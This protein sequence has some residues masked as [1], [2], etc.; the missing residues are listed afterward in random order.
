MADCKADQVGQI[1]PARRTDAAAGSGGRRGIALETDCRFRKTAELRCEHLFSSSTPLAPPNMAGIQRAAQSWRPTSC[2]AS[3]AA[4]APCNWATARARLM[5]TTGEPVTPTA[6]HKGRRPLPSWGDPFGAD[7][8]APT[9]LRLRADNGQ[10]RPER[11]RAEA[12]PRLHQSFRL[13]T[14]PDPARQAER[15]RRRHCAA[16]HGGLRRAA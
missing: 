1:K 2:I 7:R 9:E 10:R 13:P 14:R 11:R 12:A 6:H 15:T 4:R 3:R 5:A 8:R 16:R